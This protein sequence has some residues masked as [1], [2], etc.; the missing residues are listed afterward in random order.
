MERGLDEARQTLK[1]L[2]RTLKNQT[3]LDETG[4]AVLHIIIAYADTWRVLFEHD[5]DC[6]KT[7][8]SA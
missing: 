3:L 1:L 2:E 7:P 5:E 4:R 6:L 8:G